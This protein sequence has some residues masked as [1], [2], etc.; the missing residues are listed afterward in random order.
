M[1][2]VIVLGCGV[3]GL[4]TG[5]SL[6]ESGFQV[7]IWA[8]DL[9]PNTTSDQAGAIWFPYQVGPVEKVD[10]WGMVSYETFADLAQLPQSG[11]S[12][13]EFLMVGS[14][15]S[16][17]EPV[18]AKSLP[19]DAWSVVTG[20]QLPEGYQDGFKIRVPVMET[21][22]YMD[23]LLERFRSGGGNIEQKTISTFSELPQEPDVYV[24]CTGLGSRKLN[25]DEDLRPNLGLTLVGKI[26]SEIA[27][28]PWFVDDGGH[29]SLAYIFP[30]RTSGDFVLGG[31]AIDDH[32]GIDID[33]Q[34]YDEILARCS[35]IFPAVGKV[36]DLVRR[37][38][39]RPK[40]GSIR[41]GIDEANPRLIHNYGHGGAGFT[42]S[43]GCAQE[44]VGLVRQLAKR[45]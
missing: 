5:I 4:S 1:K 41:L 16:E 43:W 19:K 9:P 44:V 8:K 27:G 37:V 31:T 11:V 18:W 23:Y 17:A 26:N 40:R 36:S 42:V 38:G 21:P 3:S 29:N 14:D 6:Q 22:I 12:F 10:R 45:P 24:N 30:R 33:P 32:E 28:L 7:E 39:V 15:V 20:D 2:N 25:G 34:H 35:D 13:E